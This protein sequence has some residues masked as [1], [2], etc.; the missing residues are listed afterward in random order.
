MLEIRDIHKSYELQPLLCGISFRISRSETVCLLGPSGS[1]KSTILQIIAGLDVPE[2]GQVLWDGRDLASTPPHQRDFGLVFQDYALFPH[3]DVFNN[4]AFGPRMKAWS[5][6]QVALR[7]AEVLR[8]V[9]LTGFEHRAVSDLS[10]GEQQ[11][12]AL[13]RA[14]APRPRLLMFDEPLGALDRAL[15][16]ELLNELRSVLARTRIPSLYVTHDQEEAFKIGDRILILHEGR[17]VRQ[18]SPS[19]I[20]ARPGSPWTASFLGLGNVIPGRIVAGSRR[21]KTEFGVFPLSCLHDH[22]P[23]ETVHVLARPTPA[24]SGAPISGTVRDVVFRQEGYRVVLSNGLYVD[25]SRAPKKGSRLSV[26]LRLECLDGDA[27][28]APGSLSVPIA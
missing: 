3:L 17:I 18:G 9:D 22:R 23:G 8:I 24:R 12:V 11:R 28:S 1:G 13:A 5:D 27:A 10:G 15:R 25:V 4:V 7:V 6:G 16:E 20:W 26:L 21:L 14:L 2:A 19:E